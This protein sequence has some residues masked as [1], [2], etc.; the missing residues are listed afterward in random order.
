MTDGWYGLIVNCDQLLT[1]KIASHGPDRPV[2][3]A[4][5]RGKAN[6]H[7]S[8]D[9]ATRRSVFAYSRQAHP[10][11]KLHIKRSHP[12]W[13]D[14]SGRHQLAPELREIGRAATLGTRYWRGR[15]R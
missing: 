10:C 6:L 8:S 13:R 15:V 9:Y 11:P 5:Y 14:Q 1:T 4:A 3:M 12:S 7:S 2:V